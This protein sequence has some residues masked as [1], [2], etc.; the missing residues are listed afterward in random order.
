MTYIQISHMATI[1]IYFF[2]F[3]LF[4]RANY[5]QNIDIRTYM[6][7]KKIISSMIRRLPVKYIETENMEKYLKCNIKNRNQLFIAFNTVK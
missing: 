7:R 2:D 5:K 4:K 1:L 6:E 3:T